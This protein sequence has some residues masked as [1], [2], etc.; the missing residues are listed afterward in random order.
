[1]VSYLIK[2]SCCITQNFPQS[3]WISSYFEGFGE[4][5]NL[6]WNW[7]QPDKTSVTHASRWEISYQ[8]LQTEIWKN[9]WKKLSNQILKKQRTNT[10]FTR[11]YVSQSKESKWEQGSS[12]ILPRGESSTFHVYIGSP[13][14]F[15]LSRGLTLICSEL[16]CV[17]IFIIP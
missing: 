3:I 15:I 10:R 13:D 6:L 2:M 17:H 16:N 5:S 8:R 9:I 7:N 4:K 11:S 12:H 14:S 1:M